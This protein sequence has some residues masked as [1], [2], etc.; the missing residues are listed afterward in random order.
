MTRTLFALAAV[1]VTLSSAP[2]PVH[3]AAALDLSIDVPRLKVAEYHRP[4]VAAWIEK[5]DNTVAANLTVWYQ[6]NRAEERPKQ[7]AGGPG[8]GESGGLD[9]TKWLKDLRQ[10]WRRT[11]RN[12]TMPVDGVSGATRPEGKHT[13]QFAGDAA[14][15]KDLAP[16]RYRL[17]VEAAREVGGRELLKIE[18][19]WPPA[20]EQH[21][22]AQGKSELGAVALDLRP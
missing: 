6:H 10:W 7:G 5:P 3:A 8:G 1:A 13:L 2:A 22:S 14:P 16:G 12:L 18:F 4:Y 21:L 15:L 9:G 17:V 20:A 11:G 19:V